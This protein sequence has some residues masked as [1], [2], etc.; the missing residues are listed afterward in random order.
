MTKTKHGLGRV[1]L[2]QVKLFSKKKNLDELLFT[3]LINDMII[4]SLITCTK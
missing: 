4:S 2:I 3:D 1:S